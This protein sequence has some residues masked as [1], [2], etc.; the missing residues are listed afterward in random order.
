DRSGPASGV[1]ARA[2]R[3]HRLHGENQ[4]TRVR[5]HAA[6]A[7][8][9][10][11]GQR[12]GAR[13]RGVGPSAAGMRIMKTTLGPLLL[14]IAFAACAAAQ[15]SEQRTP[16]PPPLLP[17]APSQPAAD[18]TAQR[19]TMAFSDPSRPG[20]L[21]VSIVMGSITVKGTNRRDVLVE[22]RPRSG[23][24][25]R[26][27]PQEEPPPGLRRL[28]QNGGFTVAEDKNQITVEVDRATL[29]IDLTIEVPQRINLDLETVMGSVSVEGV[30][31]ELEIE[32]V[33]GAVTL[34]NVGGSVVAH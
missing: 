32:S 4:R 27:R 19:V 31:G 25:P 17:P 12:R 18:G 33:N 16:E 3:A 26:R 13:A 11:A 29:Q 20:S 6:A 14:V 1:A 23:A 7:R 34:T 22:G 5:C 28:T 9:G 15:P 2:D 10:P 21:D 30:D 8:N 24:Q